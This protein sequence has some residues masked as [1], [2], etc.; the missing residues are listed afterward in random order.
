[1][2]YDSTRVM[3]NREVPAYNHC[4]G[5]G[6]SVVG[7]ISATARIIRCTGL[8]YSYIVIKRTKGRS[9]D[10]CTL[11]LTLHSSPDTVLFT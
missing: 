4:W 8:L 5:G 7:E 10:P 9:D 6:L 2:V 1:M 3:G 11:R